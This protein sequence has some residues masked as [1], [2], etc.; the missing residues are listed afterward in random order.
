LLVIFL[1]PGFDPVPT[2]LD[3]AGP[4]AAPL[5][6]VF[7]ILGMLALWRPASFGMQ[8]SGPGH[9][10]LPQVRLTGRDLNDLICA[11]LC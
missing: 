11:H 6:L 10:R 3:K 7:A 9:S 2:L 5:L 4:L 8:P 1:H